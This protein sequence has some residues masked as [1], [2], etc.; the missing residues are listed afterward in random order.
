MSTRWV[1][2]SQDP[3]CSRVPVLPWL[4]VAAS[5]EAPASGS[6]SILSRRDVCV[7]TARC[8]FG[9]LTETGNASCARLSAPLA[10]VAY[11]CYP[12]G[13][14]DMGGTPAG[15]QSASTTASNDALH[16]TQNR[17]PVVGDAS[18]PAAQD[19]TFMQVAA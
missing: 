4:T 6:R 11:R 3:R 13:S 10:E 18:M 9:S 1:T 15:C 2:T 5:S 12:F 16:D 7:A 17:S 8:R 14:G 19:R